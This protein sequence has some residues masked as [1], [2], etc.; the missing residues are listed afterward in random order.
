MFIDTLFIVAKNWKQY[1]RFTKVVY[2]YDR[3]LHSNY[4]EQ[5]HTSYNNM[6]EYGWV[7]EAI[8]KEY[9]ECITPL[10]KIS[11][12]GTTNLWN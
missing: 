4:N 2:S 8:Y 7:K 9:V 6:D 10:T 11:K 5:T 1:K 12:P 3:I